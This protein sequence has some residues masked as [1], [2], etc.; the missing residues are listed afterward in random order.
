MAKKPKTLPGRVFAQFGSIWLT[1]ALLTNLFLLTWL[2][3]LE[4]VEKGIHQVQAEYFES[5]WVLA[6]AGPLKVLLPGGYFTMGL[7]TVNLVIGGLIRIRKSKATI[8]VI[9]GHVGIA[10]MMIGGLVEHATSDYGRI[11]LHTGEEG[12]EFQEYEGWEVAI[13]DADA[14]SGV[15]EYIIP[16]AQFT[17]LDGA[18]L[19]TFERA[20]LPFDLVLS[21]FME[22]CTPKRAASSGAPDAPVVEGMF[23]SEQAKDPENE[24]NIAGLYVKAINGGA[25]LHEE[26]FLFGIEQFPWVFAAGGKNW[27]VELRHTVHS[28]PFR[29]RLVKF[30]KDDHPGMSMARAYF[31]DVIKI[32]ADGSEHPLRIEMNK[33]LREK[34]LIVYQSGFG[35]QDGGLGEPYSVLAVSKNPSDRIPWI[36]VTV[37]AVGLL[38]TFLARLLGFLGKERRRALKAAGQSAG[39]GAETKA[40]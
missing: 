33:P 24:R 18:A 38:W 39:S 40:A 14:T 1:I 35:P 5:W 2:G 23:L 13:W 32:D 15:Q 22:N 20:D 16:G 11:V 26:T 21:R 12:G 19:R 10:L 25:A 7:F 17:G 37:I 27:A 4:Q 9:I 28:M 36:S 34:G 8:G 29:L 6:K 3:T 31:S 30:T